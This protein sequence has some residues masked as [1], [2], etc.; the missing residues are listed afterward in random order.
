MILRYLEDFQRLNTNA[1]NGKSR[2]YKPALLLAVIEGIE[3]GSVQN[4]RV[5]IT[6]ELIASFRRQLVILGATGTYQSRH[7]AYPFYHLK[8]ENFWRLK[9][10]PDKKIIVTVA[11][12]ISGLRQ[13][14]EAVD[15]AQLD[16][17]LWE[18]LVSSKTRNRLRNALLG[19]Y[20]IG[21]E[22]NKEAE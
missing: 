16:V 6:P 4:R 5:Y 14:D 7:F 8:S 13:L 19:R 10:K 21:T 15:Y 20:T 12:S 1:P 2:P 22:A 17:N 11:N 18:L 9:E 3:S